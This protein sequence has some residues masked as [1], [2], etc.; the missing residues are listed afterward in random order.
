[1]QFITDS[2]EHIQNEIWNKVLLVRIDSGQSKAVADLVRAS[3][4]CRSERPS[5]AFPERLEALLSPRPLGGRVVQATPRKTY[6]A[7]AASPLCRS[8]DAGR[9]GQG[10]GGGIYRD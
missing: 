2:Q 1:M 9:S 7:M 10:E 4:R 6:E 8:L 5:E 3:R